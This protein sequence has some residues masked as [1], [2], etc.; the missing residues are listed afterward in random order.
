MPIH[1]DGAMA[2]AWCI[3]TVLWW[4]TLK[5]RAFRQSLWHHGERRKRKSNITATKSNCFA[6]DCD[7]VW[8]SHANT[9]VNVCTSADTSL[10]VHRWTCL[11]SAMSTT[12]KTAPRKGCLTHVCDS[13]NTPCWHRGERFRLRV[14]RHLK[15][16]QQWTCLKN[17]TFTTQQMASWKG[18]LTVSVTTSGYLQ[19]TPW[20]K[21]QSA[22]WQTPHSDAAVKLSQERH[23]HSAE[24]GLM[25]RSSHTWLYPMP[26]AQWKVLSMCWR[27]CCSLL[28]SLAVSPAGA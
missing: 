7:W 11:K 21:I 1:W 23:I 6:Y 2:N 25:K 13:L 15:R 4:N 12:Q 17:A 19:P 3:T 8:K 26:T 22:C 10:T 9:M 28:G 24:N 16:A 18:C 20:W 5:T 27:Q 14:D